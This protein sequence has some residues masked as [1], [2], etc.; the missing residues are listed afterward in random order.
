[1]K[2]INNIYFYD[3]INELPLRNLIQI[4]D[5]NDLK[6]LQKFDNE[7][8]KLTNK[9]YPEVKKIYENIIYQIKDL[10]VQLQL[11]NF[12]FLL[13]NEKAILYF[14]K[15]N[16][17]LLLKRIGKKINKVVKFRFLKAE[18]TFKN[19]LSE[20]DKRFESFKIIEFSTKYKTKKDFK[21]QFK[22]IIGINDKDLEPFFEIEKFYDFQEYFSYIDKFLPKKYHNV[23]KDNVLILHFFKATEIKINS[24]VELNEYFFKVFKELNRYEDYVL[25]RK[26]YFRI[27]NIRASEKEIEQKDIWDSIAAIEIYTKV[28]I[29]IN[30]DT[31]AKFIA[32]RNLVTEKIKE[33]EKLMK[34]TN[35]NG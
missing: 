14:F 30:N 11:L 17:Q 12:N 9:Q 1:M 28:R 25:M 16:H 20:L 18:K 32:L 8:K 23:L 2:K 15:K 13:E 29:D 34:K 21:E 10:D 6:Y 35:K 22:R 19:Y 31:F 5:K 3:D 27:N 4:L 7:P 24:L 26:R 33:E